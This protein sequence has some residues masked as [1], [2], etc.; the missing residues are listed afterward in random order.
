[1]D[2]HKTCFITAL[3]ETKREGI[4]AFLAYL[5]TT[6][7]YTA[8][9][10]TKFHLAVPGGLLQHSLHV[11][12]YAREEAKS[13]ESLGIVIP[14]A[15]VTLAGLL[16]DLCKVGYYVEGEEWDKEWKD[17]TNEWRKKKVFKVEDNLPLGH[18]EK[19]VIL[20]SRYLTLTPDEMAAIRWHMVGFDP[21]IHFFY[22][23]GAPYQESTKRYPLVTL[24]AIADMKAAMVEG[25]MALHPVQTPAP[26]AEPTT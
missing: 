8:P 14:Q 18:G 5:E 21:S 3:K 4:E 2:D 12:K 15:S 23:S 9:A 7:F 11:L 16:H 25:W 20:A 6:D 17:K 26:T 13:V 24:L 22:P 19:S 10:S 1:M